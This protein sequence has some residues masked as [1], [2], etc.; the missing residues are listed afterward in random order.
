MKKDMP[1]YLLGHILNCVLGI[2]VIICAP[3]GTKAL[4]WSLVGTTEPLTSALFLLSPAHRS[5]LV[6]HTSNYW[7]KFGSNPVN[8]L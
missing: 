1:V 3:I 4:G 2:G 7:L 5:D 8:L 6:L